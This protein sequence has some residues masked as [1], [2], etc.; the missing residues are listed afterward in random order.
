MTKR[1]ATDFEKT[2]EFPKAV[3]NETNPSYLEGAWGYP[4]WR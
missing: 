2:I 3:G 1:G 4:A